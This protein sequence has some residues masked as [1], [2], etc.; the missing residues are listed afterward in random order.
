MYIVVV[1]FGSEGKKIYTFNDLNNH[2][3]DWGLKVNL[4]REYN[5][6]QEVINL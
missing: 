4:L 1:D 5:G 6:H 2:A 3:T